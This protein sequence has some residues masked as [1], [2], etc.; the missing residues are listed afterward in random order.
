MP[1]KSWR[2]RFL[3]A[4]H[5]TNLLPSSILGN[6]SPHQIL[7]GHAPD[8]VHLKLLGERSFQVKLVYKLYDFHNKRIIISGDV[9]FHE[10]IFPF[11]KIT[12]FAIQNYISNHNLILTIPL[13][14]TFVLPWMKNFVHTWSV[15]PLLEGKKPI[16]CKWVYKIKHKEDGSV[17]SYKARLVTKGFTQLEGIDYTETFSQVAKMT[18]FKTW[19]AIEAPNNCHFFLQLDI[20]NAFLNGIGNFLLVMVLINKAWSVGCTSMGV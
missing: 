15:V 14:P 20:N 10:H 3:V 19:M 4:T 17:D 11:H 2:E 6:K 1:I 9:V 8:Y 13:S 12:A 7:V 18:T 5:L 16:D